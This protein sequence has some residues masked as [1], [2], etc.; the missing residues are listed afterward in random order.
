MNK[1]NKRFIEMAYLVASWSK[2]PST[3]CGAVIIDTSNRIISTGYNGFPQGT[4]D[5]PALYGNRDEK[6]RRVIHAEKNAILFAKQDLTNCTLYVVPMPPCSQ[7]AGMIIQSGISRVL[8]VKQTQRQG[9]NVPT[10][11]RNTL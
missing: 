8:T 9:I 7:C 4:S 3:Q 2:D 10:K 6:L 11:N 5:D 1:W